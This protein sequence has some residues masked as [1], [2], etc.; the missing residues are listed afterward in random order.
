MA[1]VN[2]EQ[3][4]AQLRF[5]LNALKLQKPEKSLRKRAGKKWIKVH[6][7]YLELIEKL[8]E[9]REL[10]IISLQCLIETVEL[11]IHDQGKEE[12]YKSRYKKL[13]E[14]VTDQDKINQEL[15]E[16]F[17][18]ITKLMELGISH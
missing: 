9:A 11:V 16:S 6:V 8:N 2:I 4:V 15:Y 3:K 12:R 1:D 10:L 17:K 13:R 5:L 14:R 18:Q 7:H